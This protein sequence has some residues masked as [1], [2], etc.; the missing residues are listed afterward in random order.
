M[1]VTTEIIIL[2]DGIHRQRMEPK[3]TT[4]FKKVWR[5]GR[6]KA[7]KKVGNSE[8]DDKSGSSFSRVLISFKSCSW[9]CKFE[10]LSFA[11]KCNINKIFLSI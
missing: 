6:K 1:E 10:F 2:N 11:Y 9:I 4:V 3:W 5:K 7:E 8:S